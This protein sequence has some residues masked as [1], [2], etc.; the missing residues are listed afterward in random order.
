MKHVHNVDNFVRYLNKQPVYRNTIIITS[1]VI[2]NIALC[3]ILHKKKPWAWAPT[4]ES[5]NQ[6][7]FVSAGASHVIAFI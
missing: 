4:T 6:E 2:F 7:D 1:F 5:Y 3:Y